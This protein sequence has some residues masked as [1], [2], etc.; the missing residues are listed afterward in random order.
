MDELCYRNIC[1]LFGIFYNNFL[2]F[3][4]NKET[5]KQFSDLFAY[6]QIFWSSMDE[7]AFSRVENILCTNSLP[8]TQ[9]TNTEILRK[10]SMASKKAGPFFQ[11]KF[12]LN[13]PFQQRTIKTVL[14]LCHSVVHLPLRK[15]IDFVKIG[16]RISLKKAKIIF[17]PPL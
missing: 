7:L 12:Y 9:T 6:P 14:S 5:I 3:F 2:I 10:E 13:S 15:V 8:P 4:L 1:F 17:P 11:N 16:S